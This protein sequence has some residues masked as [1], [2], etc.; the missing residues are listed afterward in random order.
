MNIEQLAG[1]IY[2]KLM[3]KNQNCNIQFPIT[4]IKFHMFFKESKTLSFS[5]DD[6]FYQLTLKEIK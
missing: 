5:L 6:K 3:N 2:D 1:S 4:E